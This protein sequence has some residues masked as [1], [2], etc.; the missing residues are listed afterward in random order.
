MTAA[1]ETPRGAVSCLKRDGDRSVWL[2]ERSGVPAR[3]V[4]RWPLTPALAF[5]LAVGRSQPQRQARATRMLRRFG[6]AVPEVLAGPRV[7]RGAG[8]GGFVALELAFVPRQTMLDRLRAGDADSRAARR[9]GAACGELIASLAAHGLL[10]RDLKLSNLIVDE[11]ERVWMIDPVGVRRCVD[12]ST[13]VFRMLERLGVEPA[14]IPCVVPRSAVIAAV[15]RAWRSLPRRPAQA[16]HR[17]RS[18]RPPH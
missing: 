8:P 16:A 11:H 15:R 4:K 3:T 7:V 2:V 14:S 13:A 5:K 9:L 6:L 18:T 10:N 17:L 12:R 1:S